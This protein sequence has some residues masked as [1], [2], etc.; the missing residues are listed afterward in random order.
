MVNNAGVFCGQ[1]KIAEESVDAFDK[2]MVGQLDIS[3]KYDREAYLYR[4]SI[5]VVSFLE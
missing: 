3:F 2:T 4:E 5:P 1:H